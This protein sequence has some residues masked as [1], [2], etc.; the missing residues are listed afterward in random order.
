MMDSPSTALSS[1]DSSNSELVRRTDGMQPW[2]RAFHATNGTFLVLALLFLPIPRGAVLLALGAL[3]AG[4]VLLDVVRLTRP[5][6]NR[7]FFRTFIRLASPREANKVASS[8]WYALG[9][10]LAL[11]LFPR[12]AALAGILTMALG[13]PAAALVGRKYGKR[14]LGSGSLEGS[15]TFALVAFGVLAL[16]APW[17][18]AAVAALVTAAVEAL[19]WPV[20]DNLSIPLVASGVLFLLL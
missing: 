3:V 10:L 16:F 17:P 7:L 19:P 5:G 15:T 20:D 11:L 2:R 4:L 14:K 8:T 9:V 1:T 6:V 18:V 13:D 12:G